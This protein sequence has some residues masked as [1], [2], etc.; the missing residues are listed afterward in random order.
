[1]TSVD[2]VIIGA[3]AGG[4]AAAVELSA[5]GL[6]V[7]VL[8]AGPD[9]GGKMGRAIDEGVEF[10]TG[11]SVLTMTDVLDS[12]FALAGTSTA[13]ELELLPSDEFRYIWPAGP[14]LDVRFTVADTTTAIQETL[15]V[16]AAIEFATFMAYTKDIW[17][18]AAPNFVYG[19]APTA[20]SALKLGVSKFREVLK[21][22]AMRTMASAINR[23]IRDPHLRDLFMRYAT[24]NGSNPWVAPATLN[25]IAWVELGL[26]AYGVRGGMHQVAQA[27]ERVAMKHGAEFRY[28]TK[29]THIVSANGKITGVRLADA[30]EIHAQRVICN[31]D[32]S[33]LV[34][35]LAPALKSLSGNAEPSMSGWTAVIKARRRDRPSHSVLFPDR[36]YRAEFEDIFDH[37]VPP[38]DPTVY[39]CAQEKAHQRSGWTDHEPIFVM[40][41]APAEPKSGQTPDEVWQALEKTVMARL[42]AHGLLDTEDKIVWR[43][44]PTNLAHQFSGSRGSI[45]GASSNSQFSAFQRPAN[46]IPELKGLYLASGSAHPG[47][48]VPMCLLSGRAAARLI[49]SSRE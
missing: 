8:E 3:G 42:V 46:S 7:L 1:M 44:T 48:G 24:Y 40:A 20:F 38:A 2:V 16:E 17:D 39:L 29:V 49:K 12:L 9:P 19:D 18:A 37:G 41:N 26:G 34:S 28:D 5:A 13:A 4:L 11:P 22:D 25:C 35:E 45:Y 6:K 14:Q 15:G 33:H 21:I 32:V 27:L 10:D 36:P 43:R 23:R 47:G 30:Q 31:A